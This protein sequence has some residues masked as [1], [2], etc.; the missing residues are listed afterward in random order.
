MD[1]LNGEHGDEYREA[2]SI[3]KTAL[4]KQLPGG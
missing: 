2:M 4:P 3:E 1:V